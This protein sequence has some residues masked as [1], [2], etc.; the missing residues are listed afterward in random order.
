[1]TRCDPWPRRAFVGLLALAAG[2]VALAQTLQRPFPANAWRGELTVGQAPGAILNGQPVRLAPGARIRNADNL[3]VLSG[4]L[5]G[6]RLL[7]HYTLD[8]QGLL[9]DAWILSPAEAARQPWPR[10]AQE[11]AALRFDPAAQVWSRP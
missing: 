8:N 7:V 3:I 5:S 2:G 6:Q 1:M 9:Q 4:T 10:N 11:A